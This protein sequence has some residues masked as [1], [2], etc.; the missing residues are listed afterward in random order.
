MHFIHQDFLFVSPNFFSRV[1][2]QIN[3]DC[4]IEYLQCTYTTV[5]NRVRGQIDIFHALI[6]K[7]FPGGGVPT[8]VWFCGGGGGFRGMFLVIFGID[9]LTPSRSAHVFDWKNFIYLHVLNICTQIEVS[10]KNGLSNEAFT[11]HWHG[12][13]QKNTPWMDGASMVTQCPINPGDTFLYR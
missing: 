6:Q 11:I 2:G 7:I 10:V 4:K 9:P 8:V 12:M 3:L 13:I 5:P 1:W